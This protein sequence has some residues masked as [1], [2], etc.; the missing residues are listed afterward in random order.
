MLNA[1]FGNVV[2]MMITFNTLKSRKTGNDGGMKQLNSIGGFQHIDSLRIDSH[3]RQNMGY[4]ES[5]FTWFLANGA[6][7]KAC[8][9][10]IVLYESLHGVTSILSSIQ[11]AGAGEN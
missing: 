10:R 8:V 5:L 2:E 7:E 6:H 9:F 1:T 11:D 4:L 3:R